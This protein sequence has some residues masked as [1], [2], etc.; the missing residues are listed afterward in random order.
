MRTI[1]F[2]EFTLKTIKNDFYV[3]IFIWELQCA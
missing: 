1:I 3:V 2:N